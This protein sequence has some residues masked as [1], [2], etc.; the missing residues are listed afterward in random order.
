MIEKSCRKSIVLKFSFLI[1]SVVAGPVAFG[2][3]QAS[4][5][6]QARDITRQF[7]ATLL[8][9]LQGALASGGP[10]KAIEVCSVRA[11]E[12]ADELS[13]E[14]GWSVR[15]VSLKARNNEKAIPDEWE[16]EMLGVFDLKQ[17]EGMTAKAL[18]HS[19]MVDGEFRYMQAQPTMPLCL[20]C[21]GSNVSEEV[22]I[23]LKR[24]YP[25]D[26]ATGYESGEI[27]GAISLRYQID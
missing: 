7:T 21:H 6:V 9:T 1:L 13:L 19:A 20:T 5:E 4:M 15:R 18:N 25:D 10:V 24:H 27:R 12:V 22:R 3:D 14:T 17:Q 11:P 16:R 26:Q 23:A 8:P 2:G